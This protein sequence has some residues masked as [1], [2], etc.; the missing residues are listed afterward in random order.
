MSRLDDLKARPAADLKTRV[1]EAGEPVIDNWRK[2]DVD[3]HLATL[4]REFSGRSELEYYHAALTVHIRRAI[5][6]DAHAALFL[7]LWHAEKDFL[8]QHLNSRWLV[9]ACD[10]F[11]DISPDPVERSLAAGA[12]L[13]ANTIKLYETERLLSGVAGRETALEPFGQRKAIHDG[14]SAF[15]IGRGEMVMNLHKRIHALAMPESA[16]Y[17]ILCELLRRA[18]V[19]DTV[20]KRFRDIHT[21]PATIW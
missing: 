6:P 3:D 20:Y 15:M 7:D 2:P 21:N 9:S 11:V 14:M 18:S 17:A 19:H 13:F 1:I 16:A 12:T 5:D 4:E 8:C 10:T